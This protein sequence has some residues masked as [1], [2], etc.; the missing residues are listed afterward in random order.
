[1]MSGHGVRAFHDGAKA[2]TFPDVSPRTV[3]TPTQ[4]T[5]CDHRIILSGRLADTALR[6]GT[7]TAYT[8]GVDAA[9]ALTLLA[10]WLER[11]GSA[12]SSLSVHVSAVL[13]EATAKRRKPAKG[14]LATWQKRKALDLLGVNLAEP[15]CIEAVAAACRLSRAHFT[16]AFGA[17]VG[18]APYRWR[19][20]RR[21]A[22]ARRLLA[23][24]D[25]GFSDVAQACGFSKMSHFSH[26]FAQAVG[27][28]PRQWR[29]AFSDRR[30]AA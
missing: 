10:D 19:M 14:M 30:G 11:E 8:P 29:Q 21:M 23:D 15:V 28:C 20:E 16:R 7:D 2:M 22:L 26:A 13:A 24:T 17:S 4:L 25:R 27:M 9:P 12:S 6:A 3:T 5:L 18:T 1:M